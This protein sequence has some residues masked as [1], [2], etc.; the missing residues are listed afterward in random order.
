MTDFSWRAADAGGKLVE[1]HIDAGSP[2]QA[3][4][5]LRQ[6]G[7]MP[8]RI[9]ASSGAGETAGA[10]LPGLVRRKG[11]AAKGPVNTADVLAITSELSVMLR[12]GLAL[13]NA[14]R[15]LV[16]MGHRPAVSE[17]LQGIL[18]DVKGGKPLS[19]ALENRRQV[20]GDFYISMIRSGELSGQISTLMERLVEHMERLRA[21]RENV[22]S[23]SIY[24]AILLGVAV[25]SMIGMLSF[26]AR[27]NFVEMDSE[28]VLRINPRESC[29][30]WSRAPATS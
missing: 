17:M 24:P 25:L 23:A 22:I 21:L 11:S 6:R 3:M 8:L 1:G 2:A 16:E 28:F 13:D 5:L 12:A 30:C 27:T 9:D 19:R 20:F 10:I 7:L 18:E 14:L 29:P 26:V 15:V 4:Q